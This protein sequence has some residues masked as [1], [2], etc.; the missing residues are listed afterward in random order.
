MIP[1]EDAPREPKAKSLKAEKALRLR[2]PTQVMRQAAAHADDVLFPV[3]RV[4]QRYGGK[5]NVWLWRALQNGFPQ[6]AMV[7]NRRRH[8]WLSQLERFEQ[9]LHES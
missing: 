8:W 1:T 4:L 9:G 5:S 2:H 7:I 3:S 6:P